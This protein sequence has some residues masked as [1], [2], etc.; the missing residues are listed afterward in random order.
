MLAIPPRQPLS[1]KFLARA[2]CKRSTARQVIHAGGKAQP[3]VPRAAKRRARNQSHAGFGQQ[4][5]GEFDIGAHAVS[6]ID[7]TWKLEDIKRAVTVQAVHTRR[8][9]QGRYQ[10]VVM[11]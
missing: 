4:L 11:F 3:H 5:L 2:F 1:L 8:L 10:P 7:G 6:G 9:V